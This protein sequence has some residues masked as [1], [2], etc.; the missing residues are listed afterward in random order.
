VSDG[1]LLRSLASSANPDQ[2]DLSWTRDWEDLLELDMYDV[3][4]AE[5]VIRELEDPKSVATIWL[6]RLKAITR[7]GKLSC[8]NRFCSNGMG[9]VQLLGVIIFAR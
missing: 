4:M 8:A 5:T 2:S 1:R 6:H 3:S 9:S 7:S